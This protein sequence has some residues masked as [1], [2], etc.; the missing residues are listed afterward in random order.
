MPDGIHLRLRSDA[1]SNGPLEVGFAWV[2]QWRLL[3][4]RGTPWVVARGCQA[5]PSQQMRMW[6]GSSPRL[7]IVCGGS[8]WPFRVKL[9]KRVSRV[10]PVIGFVRSVRYFQ[11]D[12]CPASSCCQR[13]AVDHLAGHP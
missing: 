13:Q 2:R 6:R 10:S 4:H 5:L 9:A 1:R 7:V 8:M 3:Y 12:G 11:T